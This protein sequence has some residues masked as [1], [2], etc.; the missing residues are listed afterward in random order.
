MI[1]LSS[2]KW[3]FLKTPKPQNPKTPSVGFILGGVVDE[4]LF[5][6]HHSLPSCPLIGRLVRLPVLDY[7]EAAFKRVWPLDY[8]H[9]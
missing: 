8:Y 1:I 9:Y 2:K 3:N 4:E 5:L 7:R 6:R